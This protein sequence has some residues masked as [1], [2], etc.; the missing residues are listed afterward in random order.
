MQCER[1][2]DALLVRDPFTRRDRSRLCGAALRGRTASGTQLLPLR[3]FHPPPPGSPSPEPGRS[4]FGWLSCGAQPESQTMSKVARM[5]PVGIGE[6]FAGRSRAMRRSGGTAGRSVATLAQHIGR[7]HP[8]EGRPSAR[9]RCRNA[10]RPDRHRSPAAR[11]RRAVATR[12]CHADRRTARRGGD[13]SALALRLRR[14]KT[15]A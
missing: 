2:R 15:L 6:A 7:A 3:T 10:P 12:R 4:G 8:P 9:T 5:R 13:D 14:R 1:E 11:S